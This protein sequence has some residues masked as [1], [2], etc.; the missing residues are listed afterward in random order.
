MTDVINPST[1]VPGTEQNVPAAGGQENAASAAS[2]KDIVKTATGREYP[3]DEA[4]LEGIK[5]TY[6]MVGAKLEPKVVEKTVVPET[7]VQEVETLKQQLKSSEF[8]NQHPEYKDVKDVI[9]KFGNDP[10]QVVQDPIFQKT[11]N[12]LKTASA[13]PSKSVL[14][15]NARIA[16]P[17]TD[18]QAADLQAMREGR[19]SAAE[20]MAK[21]KGVPMPT[22]Q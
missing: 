15:S 3:T 9:Q 8:Y 21:Y 10:E 16:M 20:Y 4:A 22:E 14:T 19:M 6:Q 18:N 7:V 1:A 13:E 17:Q 11:F 5:N 12:A 2:L